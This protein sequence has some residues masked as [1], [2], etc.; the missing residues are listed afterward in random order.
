MM[1]DTYHPERCDHCGA[2]LSTGKISLDA[3]IDQVKVNAATYLFCAFVGA[4]AVGIGGAFVMFLLLPGDVYDLHKPVFS[5][6]LLAT[7]VV[8]GLIV[9]D[10]NRRRL[11]GG[12]LMPRRVEKIGID[13]GPAEQTDEIVEV[14]DLSPEGKQFAR[15]KKARYMLYLWG[16]AIAMFTGIVLAWFSVDIETFLPLAVVVALVAAFAYGRWKL[17]IRKRQA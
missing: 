13:V 4:F 6:I 10:R 15:N 2:D 14:V 5:K 9:A 3:R 17:P 8:I 16:Y 1:N 12:G 11:G 7:G